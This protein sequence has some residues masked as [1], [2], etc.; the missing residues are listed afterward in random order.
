MAALTSV[1]T[2]LSKRR[3]LGHECRMKKIRIPNQ[4]LIGE[5][6]SGQWPRGRP[7]GEDQSCATETCAR[8]SWYTCRS[9][10]S[11]TNSRRQTERPGEPQYAQEQPCKKRSWGLTGRRS[12]VAGEKECI[13]RPLYQTATHTATAAALLLRHW[14][15][16]PWEKLQ[17]KELTDLLTAKTVKTTRANYN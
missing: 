15:D 8:T 13:K 6:T 10:Q 14:Q 16:Q 4:P 17:N 2:F 11:P 1:T 9:T 12:A 7:R 5:L 3:K